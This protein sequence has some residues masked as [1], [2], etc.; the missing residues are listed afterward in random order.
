MHDINTLEYQDDFD[1][2]IWIEMS[3]FNDDIVHNIHRFLHKDGHLIFDVRNPENP[4]AKKREGNWRTWREENGI[5][6]LERHEINDETG[7]QEDVWITIDTRKGEMVEKFGGGKKIT[8]NDKIEILKKT[9]FSNIEL[10]TIGGN[11]FTHG[12]EPYWLWVVAEK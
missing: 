6:Y 9:G 5:F 4:K 7:E 1:L 12:E 10:M 2:V 3:F 8:L 11:A